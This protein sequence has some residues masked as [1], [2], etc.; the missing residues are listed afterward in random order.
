[1]LYLTYNTD[2]IDGFGSQY[3]RIYG[4]IALAYKYDCI[5]VYTPIKHIL[6][7]DSRNSIEQV[8]DYFQIKNN[9]MNVN[10]IVYDEVIIRDSITEDD[11]FNNKNDKKILIKLML[12]YNILDSNPSIY[13]SCLPHLKSIKK[14]INIYNNN[15]LNIAI[16]I[17]RGDVINEPDNPR[18][19]PI[20]FYIDKINI[21][22][23]TYPD[24]IIYILTE[25]TENNKNEFDIFKENSNI[26]LL[27]DIDTISTFEYFCNADVLI[28]SRSTFS[29]LAGIYNTKSVYYNDGFWHAK[30]PNWKNIE[31][32]HED[33]INIH[34]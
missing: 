12:P 33:L 32:L 21:I 22:Q 23:S 6:R 9:F 28:I 30:L 26:M 3:Q 31:T 16:H 11:I 29:Y 1:M 10:D 24:S 14:N 27:N 20:D 18:Y 25:I 2:H 17:R 5:Y 19:I 34:C 15:K 8:E 4:T 7:L 13:Y